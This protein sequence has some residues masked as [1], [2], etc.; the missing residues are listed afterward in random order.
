MQIV[1]FCQ[2]RLESSWL[3]LHL[4]LLSTALCLPGVWMGYQADDHLHR[5]ALSDLPGLTEY[6]RTPWTLFTFMDGDAEKNQHA[7]EEGRLPWWT[8]PTIR[9]ALFRP[10]TGWTHWLDVRL[11]PDRPVPAHVHSLVWH[12]AVIMLA[13][14]F[15]Q[16]V[17]PVR[18]VAG[19]AALLY[20]VDDARGVPAMWIANRNAI[21][22]MAFVLL[23]LVLHHAWRMR[24]SRVAAWIAPI[25]FGL[26]LCASEGGVTAA[27]YLLAFALFLEHGSPAS[28]D[29]HE[30]SRSFSTSEPNAAHKG[31]R[32]IKSLMPYVVVGLMWMVIYRA[33]GFGVWGLGAYIDP[34]G[35]PLRFLAALPLRAPL[36]LCGLFGLPPAEIGMVVARYMM[37]VVLGWAMLVVAIMVYLLLPMVRREPVARFWALGT[38]LAVLPVCATFPGDRLLTFAGLGSAGLVAM[39]MVDLWRRN[40][41]ERGTDNIVTLV[42]RIRRWGRGG[43]V[44]VLFYVHL[45][46]A[47]VSLTQASRGIQ[48]FGMAMETSARSLPAPGSAEERL[49]IASTP[50]AF[51]SVQSPV[52]RATFGQPT[53]ARMLVL[54]STVHATELERI[55]ERTILVRPDG[56]YL[57]PQGTV[58]PGQQANQPLVDLHY[59]FGVFDHL[60]RAPG[61]PFRVGESYDL[62]GIRI[63][64][65]SLTPD[66]RPAE[67]AVEFDPSPDHP[68]L[69]WVNGQDGV[70]VPLTPPR[71]GETMT[72]PPNGVPLRLR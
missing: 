52:I 55:D 45:L 60:F 38:G 65:R 9:A 8:T 11:W 34:A 14:V 41:P 17:M 39:L 7:I 43:A 40:V 51:I 4:A 10:L 1:A 63:T 49:I 68:S 2:K 48:L 20:A 32:Y 30:I 71:I 46:F 13:T 69:R 31:R 66:G 29:S 37:P 59:I 23:T 67:V 33:L 25:A 35:D 12:A 6:R 26:A 21:T 72:L 16:R 27:G 53:H 15:F 54:S 36:I 44:S 47:P 19:L 64:I 50:S 5:A 22:T 3:P 62:Q 57:I 42:G 28:A 24:G 56:G 61:Q 70:Y 18:W 58:P